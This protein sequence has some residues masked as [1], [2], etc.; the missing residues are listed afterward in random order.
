MDGIRSLSY[1]NWPLA[2]EGGDGASARS[3]LYEVYVMA[4]RRRLDRV[5]TVHAERGLGSCLD[6]L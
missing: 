1:G 3:T 4:K 5:M 2:R 6:L